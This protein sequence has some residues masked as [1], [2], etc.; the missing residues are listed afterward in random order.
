MCEI[1]LWEGYVK[2][3]FYARVMTPEGK[4]FALA[5][6]PLFRV[7]NPFARDEV[8][9]SAHVHLAQQLLEGGWKPDG[10]GKYW[11]ELRFTLD[12]AKS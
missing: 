4:E 6:S 3:Q 5:C 7:K 1:A 2:S 12:E 9:R 8:A 11:W 10:R